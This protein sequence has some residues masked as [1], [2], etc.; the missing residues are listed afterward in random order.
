MD[1]L[2][3][4]GAHAI[5]ISHEKKLN[6]YLCFQSEFN[7]AKIEK[8]AFYIAADTKYECY[9]NGVFVGFG[10]FE[11]Y[12]EKKVYDEYD[13]T[14]FLQQGKNLIS[15]LAYS[16]G[17]DS[18][19]HLSG[20]P[21][22]I[23][24]I[25][26]KNGCL[27]ASDN[28]IKCREAKEFISGDFERITPQRS[29]N[30]GFDLRFDDGWRTQ[31][32]SQSWANA[33]I[34]DDS[35]ISYM[36]RPN[37]KLS[38]LDVCSGTVLTQGQF[39]ITNGKSVSEQMQY[40]SLAYRDKQAVFGLQTEKLE[41]LSDNVYWIS[42]LGE[43]MAGYLVLDVEADEG[44]VLDIACGE[45]LEDMRVRSY[46]G[47]R[48]FAFRCVCRQGRQKIC[49]YIRRLA[50]RYL[51]FF[52]HSGIRVI[53]QA[54]LHEVEYPLE[55]MSEFHSSDRLFNQ[56]Y[57]TSVRTL[58]LCMHEHYED[59]P[60]R[61]QALYGMDSRNQM[62]TGYY[63]FGETVM[64]RSSLELLAIGQ[65]EDGLFEI[66][67]P[68]KYHL[69]IP[70]FA[71]A[72]VIALKE[73]ALFSGD[74]RFVSAMQK[75]ARN[76]LNFF[77]RHMKHDVILREHHP[78]IWNF[79]EWTDGMDNLE[80]DASIK[81]DAPINALFVMALDAYADL[82]GWIG[83]K[84]EQTWAKNISD[85]VRD[86]FHTTFYNEEKRA[87]QNYIGDGVKPIFSQLTQS[88]SLL[89]N[90]V[91][92]EL[93]K[94]IRAKSVSS[95]LVATSLSYL[96]FQYDALLQEPEVY[97]EYVLHDIE[98][99]WGHMLYHG[100]TSFWETILGEADFDRAGSLCHGWSAVP[101]YIFW[102]YIAGIYPEIPG[103]WT[104]GNMCLG[105][106]IGISGILKTTEGIKRVTKS[107]NSITFSSIF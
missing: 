71:L 16:Q 65:R 80:D 70:S 107:G 28:H 75:T 93:K 37:H 58:H 99:Q 49:F 104:I 42:D 17:E 79:Y 53:H 96:I 13:I 3:E 31:L 43:E 11:D 82:C 84:E 47:G 86:S 34:C 81:A 85:V 69:T 6:Q 88:F 32:V 102:R 91:P 73:Y 33:V 98:R 63:A 19:Q 48:N 51:E 44:A 21:M 1:I 87:Y 27:I 24:A 40:A 62:L 66:C 83:Q 26:T 67:A 10:Q 92:E 45:H 101:I 106:T 95:D 5:W 54:G 77:V 89:A 50:G 9:I 12:P 61:E 14:D 72:W 39:C 57:A 94:E 38:L 64:P 46:V 100:A 76:V 20:L 78:A 35:R 30:F 55:F 68:A 97:G 90:C 7:V 18:F 8:A 59:C 56:I 60:Q 25:T 2:R 52:A 15:V 74:L 36:P 41:L 29:F 22:V 103:K 4:N 23:F 105:E